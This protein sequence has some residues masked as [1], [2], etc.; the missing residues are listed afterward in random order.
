M[1][2]T[3]LKLSII[4]LLII[5]ILFS[6]NLFVF[7]DE[8]TNGNEQTLLIQGNN[9]NEESTNTP[10]VVNDDKYIFENGN[11]D[12]NYPIDGNLYAISNGKITI[13]SEINGNIFIFGQYVEITGTIYGSAYIMSAHDI[14]FNGQMNDLY[15]MSDSLNIGSTGIIY[16]DLHS[17][18]ENFEFEGIVGRNANITCDNI[19]F[20]PA[21]DPENQFGKIY[22]NLTYSSN[23][24][25]EDLTNIVKGTVTYNE[26]KANEDNSEFIKI[27]S[28]ISISSLI[29]YLVFVLAIYGFFKLTKNNYENTSKD[30]LK[31]KVWQSLGLGFAVLCAMPIA[32]LILIFTPFTTRIGFILLFIYITL[33]LIGSAISIISISG[34]INE[35]YSNLNDWLMLLIVVAIKVIICLI[36][37]IGGFIKFGLTVFGLGIFIISLFNKNNKENINNDN[38]KVIIEN[39]NE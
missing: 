36:P 2:K 39:N 5:T 33:L 13:S 29:A 1:L 9:T 20:K 35:K 8:E 27:K 32:A 11:I 6:L 15:S 37:V 25:L 14:T 23:T 22:G 7:S 17:I 38:N 18:S 19:N 10:E 24:K 12:I 28:K 21:E 26:P 34:I 4:I 3:K 31:N 30:I 16:R